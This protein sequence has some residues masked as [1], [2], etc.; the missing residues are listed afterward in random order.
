M[1]LLQISTPKPAGFLPLPHQRC[2]SCLRVLSPKQQGELQDCADDGFPEFEDSSWD[3]GEL[4]PKRQPGSFPSTEVR[5]RGLLGQFNVALGSEEKVDENGQPFDP[6]RDGPLRYLG[7]ANE[8]GEA[9]AAWLPPGGV[10]FSYAVAIAYVLVDTLDKGLQAQKQAARQ[11]GRADLPDRVDGAKLSNLLAFDRA[12][13]TV[14]WQLLAS[15]ICPGY[16][17]HTIVWLTHQALSQLEATDAA[18]SAFE[19]GA[20]ALSLS[21]DV[22]ALVVDKS[23]PTAVGLAAIPF[24]VH[25]IDNAIHALM[26]ATMRPAM[27]KYICSSGGATAGLDVCNESCTPPD[28]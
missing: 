3:A 24:I 7:Y 26:N 5:S 27:R 9:F 22:L 25:P 17:I 28:A 4:L 12:L 23:L 2:R 11:L 15:V 21:G 20:T 1:L 13:D 10:P 16:T 6:L 14:V 18:H 8:C 19:S